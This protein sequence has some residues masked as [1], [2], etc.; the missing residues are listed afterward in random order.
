MLAAVGVN[1]KHAD[2]SL[3]EK[4]SLEKEEVEQAVRFFMQQ[5]SIEECFIFSTCNRTELYA[6][7]PQK[8]GLP[9]LFLSFFQE[10]KHRQLD[11]SFLEACYL[12]EEES[13]ARHLFRVASGLDSMVIGETEILGQVKDAYGWCGEVGGAGVYLHSL[14]QK[15]I[16]TG[17]KVHTETAI[18]RHAVSFGYAAVEVARRVFESLQDHTLMVVG[19]GE[20]A[21]LTLKNLFDSGASE[22]IVASRDEN[23]AAEIAARF[24]GKTLNLTM[25]DEGLQKADVII[26]ATQAPHYIITAERLRALFDQHGKRPL[27]IVDLGVPRNVE[28]A[29]GSVEGVHLY[30]LDDIESI[31]AENLLAREAEA[32]K[33]EL[34][35]EEQV[36]EFIRWYRRQ[37]AIPF[38]SLLRERG[39][40]IRQ[41]KLQEFS[42]TLSSLSKKERQAVDKLTKSLVHQL[43]K[44]AILNM[45][46][47][48]MQPDF[49]LAEKYARLL[50]GLEKA[51]PGRDGQK[52]GGCE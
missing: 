13:A 42:S 9:R 32:Q 39:E 29:A 23:R 20:M 5:D 8:D 1:H 45:K 38:I 12:M 7:C 24:R 44:E 35:I 11:G 40:S 27:L 6:V 4:L 14:C 49:K 52:E 47:L 22:V 10:I 30:N 25:L 19:T 26:C 16:S 48:S 28:P 41:E 15:A 36:D 50:F 51:A 17:K 3:R 33:A 31:I 34:I 2:L 46:D 21:R 43:L 37:Q 18:G